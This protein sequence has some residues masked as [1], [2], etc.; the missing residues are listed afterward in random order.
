VAYEAVSEVD[1]NEEG[2]IVTNH[3][4]EEN[5][6]RSQSEKAPFCAIPTTE[7]AGKVK[8]RDRKRTE[9]GGRSE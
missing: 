2:I 1:D 4:T 6:E 8:Y 7:H 9:R 5:S 3:A